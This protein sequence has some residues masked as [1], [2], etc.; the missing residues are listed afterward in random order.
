MHKIVDL[1]TQHA[2]AVRSQHL[3]KPSML[4]FSSDFKETVYIKNYFVNFTTIT[5]GTIITIC[6]WLTEH[7][8]FKQI[9]SETIFKIVYECIFTH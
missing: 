6:T 9:E 8:L 1:P 2:S 5:V 4:Y 3:E 7:V